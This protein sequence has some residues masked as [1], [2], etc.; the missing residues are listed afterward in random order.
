MWSEAGTTA[1]RPRKN[2]VLG[3]LPALEPAAPTLGQV[4]VSGPPKPARTFL[5][6][7]PL[8]LQ[9]TACL[10]SGER[11]QPRVQSG[12]DERYGVPAGSAGTRTGSPH[13]PT[14]TFSMRVQGKSRRGGLGYRSRLR[15]ERGH[16]CAS[17]HVAPTHQPALTRHAAPVG[18]SKWAWS[19]R[20]DVGPSEMC[21]E[22]RNT[23]QNVRRQ[24]YRR[25]KYLDIDGTDCSEVP[26]STQSIWLMTLEEASDRALSPRGAR[27]Q[28]QEDPQGSLLCPHQSPTGDTAVVLF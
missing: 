3:G 11:G 18:C 10:V 9:L 4:G 8:P 7:D 23:H 14:S 19:H 20:L 27:P 22:L 5:P 15:G 1:L 28:R 6:G 26:T 12:A 25:D 13:A 16:T 17:A 2:W 21:T 24:E